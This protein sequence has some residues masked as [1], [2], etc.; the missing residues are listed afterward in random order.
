MLPSSHREVRKVIGEK[1]RLAEVHGNRTHQPR[2][3]TRLYGF[4]DRGRHQPY[5]HFQRMKDNWDS[6][7]PVESRLFAHPFVEITQQTAYHVPTVPQ[8]HLDVAV[9]IDTDHRVIVNACGRQI[10]DVQFVIFD[11]LRQRLACH[12]DEFHDPDLA[13]PYPE[14]RLAQTHSVSCGRLLSYHNRRTVPSPLANSE[15]TAGAR[16]RTEHRDV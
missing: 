2:D 10:L 4:E 5:T 9:L 11:D 15:A 12:L 16:Q 6:S 14:N 8:A 7:G 13:N 3:S 1:G